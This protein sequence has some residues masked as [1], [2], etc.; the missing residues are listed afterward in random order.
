MPRPKTSAVKGGPVME[1]NIGIRSP[2][3]C[4]LAPARGSCVIEANTHGSNKRAVRSTT[5]CPEKERILLGA[6]PVGQPTLAP[7]AQ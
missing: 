3:Y 4:H 6:S 2:K 5:G 7:G 1:T